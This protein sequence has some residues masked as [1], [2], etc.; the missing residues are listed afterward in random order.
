MTYLNLNLEPI[1]NCSTR[2][3]TSS[4][5]FANPQDY[6][7]IMWDDSSLDTAHREGQG[8]PESIKRIRKSFP[9]AT[10]VAA[11]SLPHWN[12]WE[13]MLLAG[14][15]EILTKPETGMGLARLLD[16]KTQA[17]QA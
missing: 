15:N 5:D 9:N 16:A 13:K 14:A 12:E 17:T 6:D 3:P 2:P 1:L 10:I 11:C 4:A 7:L 8:A